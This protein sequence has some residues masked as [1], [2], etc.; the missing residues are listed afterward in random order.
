MHNKKPRGLYSS[1]NIIRCSEKERLG[2]QGMWH[3]QGEEKRIG[4][5]GGEN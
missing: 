4:G 1:P 3:A 5:F 2:G